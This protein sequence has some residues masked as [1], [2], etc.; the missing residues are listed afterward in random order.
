[1]TYTGG[2]FY[3]KR[4]LKIISVIVILSMIFPMLS[5]IVQPVFAD[6]TVIK[7][8]IGSYDKASATARVTWDYISNATS[9]TLEY[10][11]PNGT[12]YTT[13]TVPLDVTKNFL[14]VT[15]IKNDVIYDFNVMLT[16]ASGNTYEGQKFFLAQVSLYAEQVDQQSVNVAGGGVE[17]GVYP[18]IK[19]TW[20]MPKVF[21]NSTNTMSYAKDALSQ[22]DG[23]MK[24]LNF[25]IHMKSDKN[26]A[27]IKVTM[28]DDGTGYTAA[29][30]GES[31]LTRFSDVKY[32][33]ATGKCTLY[34]MGVKDNTSTTPS[35]DDIRTNKIDA[36]TGLST[37]PTVIDNAGDSHYVL[38]H[39]EMR[40]G[41]V[42]KVTMNTMFVDALGTYVATVADGLTE[43]PL[44]GSLD[45]TYTPV[46]FQLTKDTFDNIYVKIFRINQ[47]GVSLPKLYY[48]VQT[49]NV[50]S[51]SDT[52]WTT[53][54][55]LDDTY[56]NGE[57]AITV[58][59]GINPQN[60]V[61]YRT[62]VK[63]DGVTD[64]IA[65]LNLPYMMQADSARPPVPKNIIIS[66]VT[67]VQPPLNSGITDKSSDITITWDK[68]SNW[69]QIKGH[70][71][72]DVYFNFMIN[73]NPKDMG[74]T[75]VKLEANGK[76]YGLYTANYRLVKYVSANSPNIVE[77]GLKLSYTIKGFD[78]FKGENSSG[79][80]VNI[81]NPDSYPTYLLPN[82]T[83]YMQ[84]YTSLVNDSSNISEKSLVKSF[85]TLS[86]TGRDVPIPNYLE[87]VNTTVV[88][89]SATNPANATIQ[90]RFDDLNIDWSN[91]TTN[92]SSDD[93]IIY[94]L[95]MSNRPDLSSFVTPIGSTDPTNPG[96]VGFTKQT[97]G[98]TTWVYATINQFTTLSNVQKFG[99]YL[100]PN[101]TY[102]FMLKV[103][104]KCVNELPQYKESIETVLLPI[105][106]PSGE[107][108]TPD[109][110]EKKPLAPSDFHI[111]LDANGNPMVTGQTVTFEWTVQ[112][113]AATYNLIAT[114]SKVA[115]NTKDSDPSILE[116]T[117]FKSF[118]STFG[119]MDNNSDNNPFRLTLNPKMDPLASNY[120]YDSNTKKCR[121]TIN[122]WLYPN[123]VYYFSLRSEVLDSGTP[124]S[125]VWISIPV[126][127]SLIE[128][129]S[130][131]QVVSN[132]ELGFYWFDTTP[133][134]TTENYQLK[135]KT[136]TESA[137]TLLNKSQYTIVKNG[138]VYYGRLLKLK[139][140]TT[141]N[142]QVIRTTD[143]VVLSTLTKTTREDYYQIDLKW[144]GFAIDPYSGF[145]IA[146]KT[147]DDS[148]YVLLKNDA[149]LEQY[150]DIT[151][152]TYP[153]YIE[154]SNSNLNTNYFTYNARIKLAPTKLPDGT[155]EHRPL[156]ANTKYYIKV[157]ATKTDSSDQTA[158]TPSKY[159]GPVNTR[160]EFNQDEYNDNDN[161][162]SVTAKFLDMVNKLEQEVT[163]DVNQKNGS[164][165][166][167]LVRDE[168]LINM[169]QG[170]GRFT[171][172]ID[173]S[174]GP[175]YIYSDEIY[176]AQ[177]I[178][179]AMKSNNRSV[180]I[181]AKDAEFTLT[182]NTFD[183]SNMQEF[184][185]ASTVTGSKD[186]YLKINS[187]Q[188]TVTQSEIPQ[189]TTAATKMNVLSAQT[190]ASRQT[191]DAINASIKDKLYNDT[192]GLIA[193]KVAVLKNPNNTSVKGD[194]TA[195]NKY[196][197]GLLDEIRSELSYYIEDTLNGTGYTAGAFSTKYP[198]TKYSAAMTVKMPYK[199]GAKANPYVQYESGGS[200][201][202]L[203]QNLKDEDGY[204]SYYV[205]GTGKYII[206]SSKSAA[207]TVADTNV[208]K[209]YIKKFG[210]KYDLT[211]VFPGADTSFNSDLTVTVK[212]A[213][214]LYE[215]VLEETVDKQISLKNK[216]K[217]YGL[218][219]IINTTNVNKNLT[220][221]EAAALVIKLHCQQ[222]GADYKKIRSSYKKRITD[223]N[224]ILAKYAVP[225]YMC[226]Q[227]NLMSL[228]SKSKFNPTA[229]INR[230]GI[231][232]VLQKMLDA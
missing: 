63:S 21:N 142:I 189:G 114:S 74:N 8:S 141:Y 86:P 100:E 215:L 135:I 222:T 146:I 154:K 111:A 29:L 232:T 199:A 212:E 62:V 183:T 47:G 210:Q 130:Q 66:N 33:I 20:N 13:V 43:I 150:V 12:S 177:D 148:D 27:D 106:T 143:N 85:T 1:M 179:K 11:V 200:W 217:N 110:T 203:T 214:L 216:A 60:T 180:I 25:T 184:K 164:T 69:D 115:P 88:P 122:T 36:I 208:M 113:N 31:D 144:Q 40:P 112:E 105:T 158:V 197:A 16:D 137:F 98:N 231:I 127:T 139:P 219:K 126:T 76:D 195:V 57:Y 147:E 204:L 23:A 34:V 224:L 131:L 140:R 202:K 116:D 101:T 37:I 128:P 120:T 96:D 229:T 2:N 107:P 156:K 79:N 83:Y 95:Y 48:E 17:T 206:L 213:I 136:S 109:D 172:T 78:L 125:S 72:K 94:D 221:Q 134:V 38:P 58:V 132:C 71:D 169:L 53:R 52:S 93:A 73:V 54:K 82:K 207:D 205:T 14:N 165:N 75:P 32:E 35:M 167:I 7:V 155:I 194:A 166:K 171:C 157:R 97:I 191:N 68:P 121:Y 103:R 15:G 162:T 30:S 176:M 198:I 90:I 5:G 181:K 153:Y 61:Y 104:L 117:V 118:I 188:K 81:A 163:W 22:I 196:L 6:S 220:R 19:Y 56:F 3:M 44:M 149:D 230:A 168:R 26:L 227:M 9:G 10:H 186:V 145:E 28:K 190:V 182:P 65:S 64:R 159:V 123:K 41:T 18:A 89:T 46:R 91:Y 185:N 228:D 87:W 161:I 187:T 209:Q 70:L 133:N 192:S 201:Q 45:Y 59:T 119:N 174:K 77:N 102:Y 173:I 152:H 175:A 42:Y 211:E 80:T 218:D 108:L 225:V 151:T 84:M 160:T 170:Y 67:L 178:L 124:R 226:L 4:K 193:R 50:P 129:P 55:K 51:D 223:D 49:S 99:N 39:A 138:S 24:K 92:H